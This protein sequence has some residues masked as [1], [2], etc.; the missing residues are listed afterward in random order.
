MKERYLITTSDQRSWRYDC[1]VL[2]LGEWCLTSD[3]RQSISEID[4]VIARPYG[5]D[6]RQK[7][8]D[9]A[10]VFNVYKDLL[11]ELVSL[12]NTHHKTKHSTK[13]WEILL[14]HWLL[15]YLTVA[16]NRY[17]TLVQALSENKIFST[18][19]FDSELYS[20]ATMTSSDFNSACSDSVWNHVFYSKILHYLGGVEPEYEY[21]SLK[22][23]HGYTNNK[24]KLNNS[25][26]IKSKLLS[27]VKKR[28]I[29]VRS[30][31]EDAFIINSYLPL[32]QE[33]KLQISLFQWPIIWKSQEF[34][35]VIPN[36]ELRKS[37]T[38]D[39][40]EYR[41]FQ[42]FV[43]IAMFDIIPTCF[44][45]GYNIL[46]YQV[47]S[48]QWPSKPKFIFT[49]NNF[50]TDEVFKAWVG[51][52]I[53][54]GVPYYTGQHGNNYGT[55]KYYG[56]HYWPERACADKFITW[57][58][59][60]KNTTNVPAYILTI[61]GNTF[62]KYNKLGC[63]IL[64]EHHMP[65][66]MTTHDSYYEFNEYQEKQ[67]EFIN[68]LPSNIVQKFII[69][70][71]RGS[72]SNELFWENSKLNLKIDTGEIPISK[73]IERS[74]LIVY[75]YDSTGVLEC[76]AMN[77]PIICFW[78]NNISHINDEALPY[79][80]LLRNVSII[81]DS[82]ADAATFIT[83][84]WHDIDLWWKS[85]KVQ[86]ARRIFCDKYAKLTLS[87]VKDLKNILLR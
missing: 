11:I 25:R 41:G 60:E 49:S 86:D 55:H 4:A 62:Q 37:L 19:V 75:S 31:P 28:I 30:N 65:M 3:T 71:Y 33:L 8:Y 20:L 9:M 44:L 12:L 53:Q 50:D 70:I 47:K 56:N 48:L 64:V 42:E 72:K 63:G 83:N 73:L 34:T 16:Y 5:V 76:L 32:F 79:Y 38:L 78:Y 59:G 58:W 69:R 81:H 15:R 27:K 29:S 52:K 22:Y 26:S 18:K 68:M 57:G 35:S 82:P 36:I 74:R 43:R 85:E 66:Q 67:I 7:D 61:A 54:E 84:I 23:I 46:L 6:I 40:K 13:Y 87:P 17:F 24:I 2:F 21:D 77:I 39:L 51:L 14:G 1:P 10:F 45:E 80:Q